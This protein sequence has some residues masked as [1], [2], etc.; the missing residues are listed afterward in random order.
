MEFP[1]FDP[2]S[3]LVSVYYIGAKPPLMYRIHNDVP[4][5]AE[6]S[7]GSNQPLTQ[8]HRHEEGGWW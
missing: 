5:W 7:A 8:P 3:K 6:G 2:N 4:L 1:G